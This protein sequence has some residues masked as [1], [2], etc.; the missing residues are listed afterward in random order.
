MASS[1]SGSFQSSSSGGGGDNNDHDALGDSLASFLNPPATSPPGPP[2]VFDSFSPY[3]ASFPFSFP[4]PPPPEH[5]SLPLDSPWPKPIHQSSPPFST[6]STST[7]ALP[8]A[9][10]PPPPSAAPDVP[11]GSK[12]RSRA[13]RRAPT[14]VL[15]TDTSNFRAMVQQ[16]TGFPTPPFATSAAPSGSFSRPRLHLFD[17]AASIS[18]YLP[19]PPFPSSSFFRTAPLSN[20]NGIAT[21][22]S[23]CSSNPIS[24]GQNP[25]FDPS[26]ANFLSQTLLQSAT[27]LVGDS[28]NYATEEGGLGILIKSPPLKKH[29]KSEAN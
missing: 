21:A 27:S 20:L 2:P 11:R 24:D 14:T 29:G 17:A 16:F 8:S 23:S 9:S 13:S 25:K 26:T 28:S 4:F 15:A 6:N 1:Y 12:K 18:T 3:L 22:A 5:N 19:K 10:A 7:A